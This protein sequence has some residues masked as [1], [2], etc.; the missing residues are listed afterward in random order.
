MTRRRTAS[1]LL[2]Q[3]TAFPGSKEPWSSH[4]VLGD[5]MEAQLVKYIPRTRTNQPSANQRMRRHKLQGTDLKAQKR[6]ETGMK[7]ASCALCLVFSAHKHGH[8]DPWAFAQQQIDVSKISFCKFVLR[9]RGER[10]MMID[11]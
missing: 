1:P 6:V 9:N 7:G 10:T 2:S 4:L 11:S 5:S 3:P 8:P